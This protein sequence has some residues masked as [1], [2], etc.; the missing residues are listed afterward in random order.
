M[1]RL[2]ITAFAAIGV[3]ALLALAVGQRR[4]SPAAIPTA[5]GSHSGSSA[6]RAASNQLMVIQ[7]DSSGQFHLTAQAN[8][9]D[10]VFLVDTG[11]D[12]VALTVETAESLGI[13]LSPEDFEPMM[14]TA[15]GV[16]RGAVVTL[17]TLVIGDSEFHNVDAIVAEG[18]SVNLL[19]QSVLGRMGKVEL[20]GD[21]MVIEGR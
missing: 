5:A 7:R 15:S 18:L 21:Q 8:G 9:Q 3:M 1:Y 6:G 13:E 17:D 11:A 19:G 4:T 12:T 2:L 20:R 16:G 10:T 14:R